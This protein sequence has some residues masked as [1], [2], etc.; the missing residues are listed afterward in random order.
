MHGISEGMCVVPRQQCVRPAPD[1]VQA[2]HSSVLRLTRCMQGR[3]L[4]T[5]VALVMPPRNSLRCHSEGSK[6]GTAVKDDWQL[7][8]FPVSLHECSPGLQCL[9]MAMQV[10]EPSAMHLGY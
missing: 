7:A 8:E 5:A 1:M 3:A 9:F 2:R 6:G 10:H 4:T